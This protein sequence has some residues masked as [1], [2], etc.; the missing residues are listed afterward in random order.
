M[1]VYHEVVE[2]AFHASGEPFPVMTMQECDFLAIILQF[3]KVTPDLHVSL[4]PAAGKKQGAVTIVV[5]EYSHDRHI[6]LR[7]L[8]DNERGDEV[9]CVEDNFDAFAGECFHSLPDAGDMVMRVPHD[10]N[11]HSS[12]LSLY[13]QTGAGNNKKTLFL[14][15]GNR[16]EMTANKEGRDLVCGL[17]SAIEGDD[18]VSRRKLL[19]RLVIFL[20]STDTAAPAF[21][22][23]GGI[24]LLLAATRDADEKIRIPALH[25]LTW[26]AKAGYGR[27]ILSAGGSAA[28]D[29]LLADPYPQVR[30]MASGLKELLDRV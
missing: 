11:P 9:A 2:P 30:Q 21:V 15:A 28:L 7:Y 13:N 1:P 12:L 17:E 20:S 23:H 3:R 25:T 4:F 18:R 24:P 8:G 6:Y 16:W 14:Q 26:L 5:P 29:V 10:P 27:E 22:S 19:S